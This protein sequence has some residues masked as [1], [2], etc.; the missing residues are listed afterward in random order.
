MLLV[1]RHNNNNINNRLIMESWKI[2]ILSGM[3]DIHPTDGKSISQLIYEKLENSKK[4]LVTLSLGLKKAETN[5]PLI[6]L[7]QPPWSQ[8][9]RASLKP[10][11]RELAMEINR[12]QKLLT[13]EADTIN[14]KA[15][16]TKPKNKPREFLLD[17]LNQFPIRNEMCIYFLSTDGGRQSGGYH[18]CLNSRRARNS[19]CFTEWLLDWPHS[20][21]PVDSLHS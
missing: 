21:S 10:T 15:F 16:N 13:G 17:W 5:V 11:N 4:V 2:L 12:R 14:N 8:Q 1:S 9:L 20:I 6:D 3:E 18:Q 7:D 19:P